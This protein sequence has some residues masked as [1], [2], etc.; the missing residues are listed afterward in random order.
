MKRSVRVSFLVAATALLLSACGGGELPPSSF[1]GLSVD[2]DSGYL[3][4]NMLA[5]KVNATQGTGVWQFPATQETQGNNGP[6]G[7]FAGPPLKLGNA[8][9]VGGAIRGDAKPNNVLY[10]LAEDSG[11][12]LW[13][14]TGAA[15]EYVDGVATDGKVIYAPNGDYSLYALDASQATLRVEPKVLWTFETG[16]KVWSQPL[17]ADGKVYQGSLD[18][19]LYALDAATGKELWRFT[20]NA[21]IASKPAL[22][23]GVLYFGSFDDTFYAVNAADGK[24]IWKTPTTAWIWCDALLLD[25]RIYVGDVKGKFYALDERTG[26]V[27]WTSEVGGAIRGTPVADDANIYVVSFDTYVYVFPRDARPNDNGTVTPTR[28]LENG[29]GRR[30]LST[31]V[32]KDDLLLVPMFDGEIK[33]TA[34]DLNNKQKAYEFPPPPKEQK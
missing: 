22:K 27:L 32:I 3:A 13:Q 6:Q 23:D 29:L 4:S 9:I 31:P 5:Y 26:K 1:P 20:A 18:H 8:I 17:V 7:P 34:I 15:A 33:I 24:L 10:A 16:N 28:L 30:L 19:N 2:G 14:F 21:S 11:A 25:G 12:I